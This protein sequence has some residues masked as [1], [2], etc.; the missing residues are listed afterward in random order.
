MEEGFLDV[1]MDRRKRALCE[2]ILTTERRERLMEKNICKGAQGD[3]Q[4]DRLAL[5]KTIQKE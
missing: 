5:E 4:N 3:R 2:K 1:S